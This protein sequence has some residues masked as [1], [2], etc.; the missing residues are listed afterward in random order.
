MKPFSIRRI[1]ISKSLFLGVKWLAV[2]HL[3]MGQEHMKTTLTTSETTI[4]IDYQKWG[5]G[6]KKWV[7]VHGL[8]S[9]SRAFDKLLKQLPEDVEAYALNLP[10][11]GGTEVGTFEI[12]MP[13]YAK[14]VQD[15]VTNHALTD[16][17]LIGHSMGGQIAMNVAMAQPDW[18]KKLIVL[19]PAGVEQFSAQDRTWFGAVVTEALYL[20]LSDAQIKQNFNLN[21]YGGTLPEDAQFMYEDRL[22]IK[23]DEEN[24]KVYCATIVRCI[25]AML[26]NLIYEKIPSIASKTLVIFGK[27]DALIPNKILHPQLNLTSLMEALQNNAPPITI[28][29]LDN[30]GHFVMWDQANQVIKL[31]EEFTKNT[32][33]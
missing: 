13:N 32:D 23:E 33:E 18:L 14:L 22:T 9:Y 19:A 24:Y 16:V 8:G 12:S 29:M 2:I 7:L 27:D 17:V 21:F 6:D 10:G 26:D 30:A 1:R 11:F 15:F 28:S 5:N 3:S 25:Y 20:N 4:E 31:I